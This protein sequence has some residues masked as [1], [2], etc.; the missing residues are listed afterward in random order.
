MTEPTIVRRQRECR[1]KTADLLDD[2]SFHVAEARGKLAKYFDL[3][4]F[5]KGS[6]KLV[7][8]CLDYIPQKELERLLKF[9][10]SPYGSNTILQFFFWD[11]NARRPACRPKVFYNQPTQELPDHLRKRVK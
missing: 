2:E 4:C 7:R 10:D 3:M 11:K 9:N 5:D 8:V 1:N 6:Y